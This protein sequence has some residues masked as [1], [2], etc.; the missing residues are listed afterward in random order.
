[1][2]FVESRRPTKSV[3]YRWLL[4][5]SAGALI[6][7]AVVILTG[8]FELELAGRRLSSTH[9]ARPFWIAAA[10][11]VAHYLLTG[12]TRL[13]GDLP[14]LERG[15]V[16]SAP[17]LAGL[18]AAGVLIVGIG[19]GTFAAR[20]CGGP[21][22][23]YEPVP[24]VA[25][26]PT[27]LDD[28]AEIRNYVNA[29]PITAYEQYEVRGV[30]HF[31]VDDTEDM[32]KQ[33]IVAG[34]AWERHLVE[35]LEEHIEPG[36]VVVE[37]GAHIGTHTVP[38]ARLVGPWGRVYA[39]EPQRKI[40]RELHHNLALN[41]VTNAVI[42]RYAVGSG[43]ARIIEMNPATSGN[44]GGT[45]VG[46]GGDRAELRTLDSFGFERVSLIK[47]DVEGYENAV[48]DGAMDTI[49]RNRPAIL[50]EI[51]GGED[52]ETASPEVRERIHVTWRKLERLG[53][54]VTPVFKHDYIALPD[55]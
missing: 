26:S 44:E 32:I 10:A 33:V 25:V 5:L 55:D 40:Y 50:I 42:L 12:L 23:E 43:D 3:P 18:A 15:L 7:G 36:T 31:F 38:I 6:W 54:T 16:R 20:E 11:L 39:F 8:G 52:Y 49:R 4:L 22:E 9:A 30:G 17:A 48:L 2:A 46:S 21:P 24:I 47:V 13:R 1:M 41:G 19:Y 29:F 34:Y 51:M 37:V 45:G 14:S 28:A 27:V 53:Y 35:L